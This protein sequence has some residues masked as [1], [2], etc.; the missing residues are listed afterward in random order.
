MKPRKKTSEA[1]LF[2]SRLDQILN[3]NHPLFALAGKLDW[4]SLED[5]LAGLYDPAVGRPAKQ[6]RLLVGLH[7]LKYAY[8]VGD[9]RVV[10][11]FLENP[12]R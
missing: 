11:M 2:R 8:G 9:E 1:D 10:E 7:Y 4:A 12:C 3:P 6:V 5:E